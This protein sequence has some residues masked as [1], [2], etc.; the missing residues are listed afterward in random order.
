M[1]NFETLTDRK[2][3]L[4]CSGGSDSTALVYKLADFCA[5]GKLD[6][7]DVLVFHFDHQLRGEASARDAQFAEALAKH[8]G[9]DFVCKQAGE[10]QLKDGEGQ[11]L[12]GSARSLRYTAAFDAA[13][14]FSAGKDFY[15]LTAHTLDDRIETFYM[16]S[17]VGTGPGGLRS[18]TF[19]S[20]IPQI[21][22]PLFDYTRDELREYIEGHPKQFRMQDELWR[23]DETNAQTDKFRT[24]VRHEIACRCKQFM[25]AS[26]QNLRRTMDL[27]AQEDDFMQTQVDAILAFPQMVEIG[28]SGFKLQPDFGKLHPAIQGR[29]VF[30]LLGKL[31]NSPNKFS[32]F[33]IEYKSVQAV[34]DCFSDGVPMSGKVVNIQGNLAVSS[35]KS[36]VLVERMESFRR[37]RKKG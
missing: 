20:D 3:V 1:K 22:H 14:E 13:E 30:E 9:F 24:F 33:R 4:M 18:I 31:L 19:D 8:F 12:E 36:G 25:P 23:E 27:I 37:R 35:N 32:D 10:G 2:L 6:S 11:N 16:R 28:E 7:R 34:L 26:P 15:L 17:I 5:E 21:K 29:C